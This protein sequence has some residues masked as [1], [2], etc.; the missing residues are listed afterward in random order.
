[1]SCW[2][3]LHRSSLLWVNQQRG[4]QVLRGVS[5]VLSGKLTS[6]HLYLPFANQTVVMSAQMSLELSVST[7]VYPVILIRVLVVGKMSCAMAEDQG[8]YLFLYSS[9]MI[10]L[11]HVLICLTHPP[12][13]ALQLPGRVWEYTYYRRE[14]VQKSGRSFQHG[15]GGGKWKDWLSPCLHW[16]FPT[17]SKN[18]QK[19]RRL[20]DGKNMSSGDGIWIRCWNNRRSWCVWL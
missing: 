12:F 7:Q 3:L 4:P 6:L 2:R 17:R 5:A 11:I 20:W 10:S 9:A 1:M 14:T 18:T 8:T 13:W 19:R 15:F 16:L